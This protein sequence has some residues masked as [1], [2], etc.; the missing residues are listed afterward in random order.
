MMQPHGA[1]PEGCGASV[2]FSLSR[3]SVEGQQHPSCETTH[4]GTPQAK[5]FTDFDKILIITALKRLL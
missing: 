1:H 4:R 5:N 2:S 3:A